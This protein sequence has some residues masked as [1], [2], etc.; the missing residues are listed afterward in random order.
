[1]PL[2]LP[3]RLPA[4][5]AVLALAGC[6]GQPP[7]VPAAASV[8][9]LASV[10]IQPV[11]VP[12]E[13]R[14]DGRVEAV[15]Q[16]TLSAQTAGRVE[17]ILFDV[18][19]A[20]PAGA[21]I[22]RLRGTEQR[23]GL[24]AAQAA[25]SEAAARE[26]EAQARFARISDM[27]AR[28]VAAKAQYEQAQAERDAAVARLAAA[29]AALDGAR[30]GLAY[31]EVRAP[32]AGI[33]SER[34]V[35]VGEAVAPGTPL[36]RAYAAGRLRV[37]CDLPQALAGPLRAAGKA[38]VYV[39]GRRIEATAVTVFPEVDTATNTVRAR[40]DLPAGI[41]DVYPGL[42]V[43]VG[44]VTG[45]E[46]RLRV[47][48]TAILTRSEVTAV[49][50]VDADGRISLRQVRTGAAGDGQVEILAGLAGGERLALDPQAALRAIEAGGGGARTR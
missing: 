42:F 20:V 37:V 43:R 40:L 31:T 35:R 24:E 2:R 22:L 27:Y 48:A 3:G 34:L 9:S 8:A 14:I 30:E 25:R 33:L 21:V 39:D 46:P 29:Q 12:L 32:Y 47:P 49:Y 28:Q 44:I 45:E 19:D 23:A 7:P 41:R 13:R 5:A 4:L 50:V 17:A 16:A 1:M 6:G 26:A 11:A 38:A 36:I 18:N 10:V 15:E